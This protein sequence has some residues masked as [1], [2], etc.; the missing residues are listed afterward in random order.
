MIE[1]VLF[2]MDGTLLDTEKY[3][4]K[5]QKQVM[6]EEGYDVPIEETY[7]FRSL[8]SKFAKPLYFQLYGEDFPYDKVRARRRQIMNEHIAKHGIQLKPYVKETLQEL[9]EKGYETVVVT[10]T[11]EK[12]ALSYLEQT[13][14]KDL[15]DQ[16]VSTSMVEDGKPC[17]D[18]YQYACEMI[19]KK[20]ENC[21]A[22]EDSPNGVISAW[23]A[24]CKVAMIPDRTGP[25][26]NTEGKT[27]YVFSSMKEMMS[28]F[29]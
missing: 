10:A 21:L 11:N 15:F 4:T 17:P 13:G 23:R 12:T 2:D 16:I 19:Q 22:V 29:Q 7:Q 14:I 25:D 26:Q 27:D 3:L 20:P 6:M 18:V 24:G 5:Y 28:V 8:A 1:A 9:R